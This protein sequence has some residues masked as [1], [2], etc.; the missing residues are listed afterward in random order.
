MRKSLLIAIILLSIIN[1]G[2]IRNNDHD[3]EIANASTLLNALQYAPITNEILFVGMLGTKS[4]LY[5]YN[6]STKEY[7]EYWKNDKE[8]VVELSYSPYKKSAFMLTA[9]QSG[10]KGVFPFINN[11]KLYS[12]NLDSDSVTFIEN[13]GSGLQVF[14]TWASDIS[15][16]V[17]LH[18]MDVVAAKYVEQNIKTYNASGKKLFDE[19]KK[20][21]L[22]KEGFPQFPT[23]KYNS[24][25]L[26]KK[27]SIFSVDSVQ[28]QIYLIDNTNNND[29]VAITKQNQKLNGV[30][31]SDDDKVLVFSTIDIT[32]GNETLYDA[33]PNTSKL[34][35]YSLSDRKILKIFDGGGL[36][37]FML[38]GNLLI[39]DDGLKNKAKIF[40][41]NFYLG[42]MIDSIKISGGCGL[43]NIP[44]IPDYGA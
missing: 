26:N 36:K 34:F 12:L 37:N 8:E 39:F 4:G 32:P 16:Q 19:N 13:I 14:S 43:K 38:N 33:E 6:F 42:Q 21:Y 30:E 29:K 11:V 40:I 3:K 35:V 24:I 1:S 44:T 22:A 9:S 15:F 18:V 25:S 5:K 10:K 17:Y 2:C 7:S 23:I 28:T 20:Y 41:Y 31:W 27:Y